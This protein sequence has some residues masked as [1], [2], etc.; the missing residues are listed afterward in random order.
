MRFLTYSR[1]PDRLLLQ[2]VQRND[3]S[4]A[5]QA[6]EQGGDVH[7]R[8]DASLTSTGLT[9]LMGAVHSGDD[10]MMNFLIDQGLD[11]NANAD[12]GASPTSI[13]WFF[14]PQR[15]AV[16]RRRGGDL[17][18]AYRNGERGVLLQTLDL[19][20]N[21]LEFDPQ[22]AVGDAS[23]PGWLVTGGDLPEL[24]AQGLDWHRPQTIGLTPGL[25][26]HQALLNWFPSE[27][28]G[29]VMAWRAAHEQHIL[30]NAL[31]ADPAG[32]STVRERARL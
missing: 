11:P 10:A 30:R 27:F 23:A 4:T 9:L 1:R 24:I 32:A 16:L 6:V 8:Y 20:K 14:R 31:I 12:D 15:F 29:R 2:A 25:T 21:R 5:R 17:E 22:A 19:L 26:P 7:Q 3:L 13:A 28:V 18:Q